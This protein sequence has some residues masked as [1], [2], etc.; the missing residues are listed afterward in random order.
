MNESAESSE[1]VCSSLSLLESPRQ[2]NKI[3]ME[4]ENAE[5]LGDKDQNENS[6]PKQEI[7]GAE[8]YLPKQKTRTELCDPSD[9]DSEASPREVTPYSEQNNGTEV[10]DPEV[11]NSVKSEQPEPEKPEP[12][13]VLTDLVS[14]DN[15]SVSPREISLF[16]SSSDS[17]R[18][19]IVDLS[20]SESIE[21][22]LETDKVDF[23]EQEARFRNSFTTEDIEEVLDEVA[24]NVQSRV[25]NSES[26]TMEEQV[27]PDLF[28]VG[29]NLQSE[30]DFQPF[31]GKSGGKSVN[32]EGA[33]KESLKIEQ[34]EQ[35]LHE[36]VL[37][38]CPYVSKTYRMVKIKLKRRYLFYILRWLGR[39]WEGLMKTV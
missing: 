34:M 20:K 26:T 30:E 16:S 22:D 32:S 27:A 33:D 13:M 24:E 2:Q 12:K 11:L 18:P 35:E 38:V 10:V 36:Q 25:N 7:V 1:S 17:S 14:T 19:K 6:V 29:G 37:S 9:T 39:D 23:C 28:D 3:N 5:N 15:D 21:S 4:E 8:L 31:E